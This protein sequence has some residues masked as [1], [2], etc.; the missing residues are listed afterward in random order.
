VKRAATLGIGVLTGILLVAPPAFA[1]PSSEATT[2]IGVVGRTQQITSPALPR[3]T[4][5]AVAAKGVAQTMDE[6]PG[7]GTDDGTGVEPPPGG[8]TDDGTGV[9]PP[10]G[11]GTDDGPG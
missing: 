4:L 3:I 2:P 10:P 6:Q 8:G 1:G 9:E 7:G 5:A 11:G